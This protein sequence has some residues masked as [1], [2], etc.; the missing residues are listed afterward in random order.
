[1]K[2]SVETMT[3][4]GGARSVTKAIQTLDL[5]AQVATDVPG[6]TVGRRLSD[7]RA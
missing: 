7:G 1:M 2:F 5:A 6:R 3:C 4:G